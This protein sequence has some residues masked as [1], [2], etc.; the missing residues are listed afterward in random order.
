MK[1]LFLILTIILGTQLNA[2][3]FS[4]TIFQQGKQERFFV[5]SQGKVII[6]S[7]SVDEYGIHK[8]RII[9]KTDSI[10]IRSKVWFVQTPTEISYFFDISPTRRK[11]KKYRIISLDNLF[12]VYKNDELVSFYDT[13]FRPL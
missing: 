12:G 13:K 8:G 3:K 9:F 1:N 7:K 4:F 11:Y 10:T 6:K 2:Q 5:K